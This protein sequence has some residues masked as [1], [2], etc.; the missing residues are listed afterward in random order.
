MIVLWAM[1]PYPQRRRHMHMFSPFPYST[2]HKELELCDNIT[3]SFNFSQAYSI[4]F[5]Q[6]MLVV[7]SLF[8]FQ[9]K[10]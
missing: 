6:A 1:E 3:A 8:G 5:A 2:L 4:K 7:L 10:A 9:A